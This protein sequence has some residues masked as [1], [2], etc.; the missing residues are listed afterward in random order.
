MRKLAR[1][2]TTI[3]ALEIL[4]LPRFTEDLPVPQFAPVAETFWPVP[5]YCP[6]GQEF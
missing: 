2:L 4:P 5:R 6:I 3:L 1:I